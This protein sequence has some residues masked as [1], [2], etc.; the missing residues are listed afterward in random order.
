[1]NTLHLRH[2]GREETLLVPRGLSREDL[3]LDVRRA[4][5]LPD[6]TQLAFRSAGKHVAFSALI[7]DGF[8]VELV[9]CNPL[10][11]LSTSRH[12]ARQLSSS[13]VILHL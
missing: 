2:N 8:T 7:P 5:E 9:V 3:A 13:F 4:L 11:A 10:G 1:M 12:Q 6:D